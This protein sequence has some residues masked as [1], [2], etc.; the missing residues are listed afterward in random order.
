MKDKRNR[1]ESPHILSGWKEIAKH[2]GLGVR[3]V[4]RYERYMGLPV[5][6]P[7]GKSR[8][9]VA[10]TKAELDAW[11]SA[12]PM[13]EV[14]HLAR[15]VPDLPASVAEGIKSGIAEMGRLRDQ[16]AALQ[17]EL[18][19]SVDLLRKGVLGLHGQI[20]QDRWRETAYTKQRRAN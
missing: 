20:Q 7:A 17:L 1:T 4:Q 10:A 15:P 16:M 5:R 6:R 3:T 9:S 2:M 12:S 8:G 11:V 13:R 18:R 19:A 14:F